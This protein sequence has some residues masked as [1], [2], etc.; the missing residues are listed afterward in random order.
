MSGF[1]NKKETE[2]KS[3]PG[4]KVLSCA[5]CGLYKDAKSPKI[6]AYGKGKKGI[7]II[8]E[9]PGEVEDRKGL[10]WQG[11][12]GRI[13]RL[14]L[15]ELGVDLFEDCSCINAVNCRP[16]DN[17]TPT[18]Y[19]IDCCRAIMV[20]KAIKSFS[21]TVILLL[22]NAALK[23]FMAH[24]WQKD[25][26]GIAKWRGWSIPDQDYKCWI[27]PTFHPSYIE[28]EKGKEVQ[29]IWE[30]DLKTALELSKKP[31]PAF[32]TP[33]IQYITDLSILT[34]IKHSF[35]FDYETTGLKPHGI[36]HRIVCAS[37]A[38]NPEKVY[39]FML[40]KTKQE[41]KPFTDLLQEYTIGKMAHNMK[42]EDAW[43][44]N[45][46]RVNVAG[47][48]FDSMLAAHVLDNRK[49]VT[50]LKF[51][52]YVTFGVVDYASEIT[53]YLIAVDQKNGNSINRIDELLKKPGGE[54]ML[55]KYCALD[56][57]YQ[58]NLAMKQIEE[59]KYQFLP[60]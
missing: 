14:T 13:L 6:K 37:V 19:E 49:G 7:L 5:S 9:A 42:F 27:L 10:P 58:Y 34:H 33:D 28:R 32:P 52:T 38:V 22:G 56:S 46:L 39:T 29:T 20:S 55:L 54:R 2:S 60:F 15:K 30:Q 44:R 25:L 17:R 1:F 43:T 35:A 11:K 12:T 24:R 45:K 59:L 23:S 51:Q 41:R 3:R 53:P 36:D 21:P 47:W 26:G 18:D 40:P 16:K 57:H 48:D 31:F 4:G 50:G 8:G